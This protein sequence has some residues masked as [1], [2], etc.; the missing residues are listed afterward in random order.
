MSVSS[1]TARTPRA[2]S[3]PATGFRSKKSTPF[4][5][6]SRFTPRPAF[7]STCVV[8]LVTARCRNGR[9]GPEVSRIQARLKRLLREHPR[10]AQF[11]KEIIQVF[12]DGIRHKPETT[13]GNRDRGQGARFPSWQL[14][15]RDP[16][17]GLGRLASPPTRASAA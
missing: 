4:G 12:Y 8:A 14:L 16:E 1:W 6:Q 3:S 10:P 13:F 17:I 5:R 15:Q 9:A 7:R 11:N 2:I